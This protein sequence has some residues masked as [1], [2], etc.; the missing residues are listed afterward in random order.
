MTVTDIRP[1]ESTA[2]PESQDLALLQARLEDPDLAGFRKEIQQA[3][4]ELRAKSA[5]GA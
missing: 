1:A 4:V 2:T 3:I 5:L